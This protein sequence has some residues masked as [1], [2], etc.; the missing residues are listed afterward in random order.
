MRRRVTDAPTRMFHWLFALCFA[1][2]YL[3]ADGEKFRSLHVTLGYMMAGLLTFRVL[4]GLLGPR[5]A[6][7]GNVWRKL[8][9]T[10][11][12]LRS[13]RR[14]PSTQAFWRQGQ[15]LLTALG[16]LLVMVLVIPLT[17]S[18]YGTYNDWGDFLGGDW[19]EE[20]HEVVGNAMLFVVLSHI[21]LVIGLSL[22]RRKNQASP[23]LSGT[24]EG[25][26]PD[27]IK[28]NRRWLATVM[29]VAALGFGAWQ[30]YES[31]NGLIS[32]SS[33]SR[34]ASDDRHHGDHRDDD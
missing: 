7:I 18:G 11:I 24:V 21:A 32:A 29:L 30:W 17:L 1:G 8:S 20:V 2:A 27:L 16:V 14:A 3:T 34:S 9:A 23:M 33:F 22:L 5:Q 13:L 10:P 31:P 12:W 4:Y 28:H 19:L 26:G 6:A 25:A 15:N